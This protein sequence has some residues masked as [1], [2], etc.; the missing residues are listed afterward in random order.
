MN[1]LK[2]NFYSVY[3]N[4]PAAKRSEIIVVVNSEP[5]TWN[6]AKIEID[7]DT[8]LGKEILETLKELEILS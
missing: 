6:S 4:I 7:N 3:A 8:N 2:A 5:F 1:D